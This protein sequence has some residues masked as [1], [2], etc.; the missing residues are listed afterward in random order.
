MKAGK[1]WLCIAVMCMIAFAVMGSSC[2]GSSSS[3]FSEPD[4]DGRDAETQALVDE[5]IA[6]GGLTADETLPDN[7]VNYNTSSATKSLSKT[8]TTQV[9][10]G[11]ALS[12]VTLSPA[13]DTEIWRVYI[14]DDLAASA[15]SPGVSGGEFSGSANGVT[16]TASSSSSAQ[17][18]FSTSAMSTGSNQIEA[19]FVPNA[20]KPTQEIGRTVLGLVSVSSGSSNNNNGN[21]T[22]GNT[23]GNSGGDN[24]SNITSDDNVPDKPASGDN[25]PDRPTSGDN[26]P[27]K[28]TSGDN[29]PDAPT[30]GD[31]VPD[32]PTSGDNVPDAP[33]SGDNVPDTPTSDDQTSDDNTDTTSDDQTGT[34]TGET[35]SSTTASTH[36]LSLT[37]GSATY[38]NITVTKTGDAT[39]SSDGTSGYDWTGSNAAVFAS[40]GGTLT[41]TSA[42]ISSS[43][44]G[45]N[46]VFSYG[47][48][49]NGSNSGNGTTIKISGSTITTTKN[50]SG[51]IMATGGGV[52]NAENLTI[53]TAGGSSA[54]IRSDRGG[55]TIT[56][57]GGT[58]TANGQGSP[59]I[60]STAEITGSDVTLNSG[61]AQVVVIEGGN[62][63]TLT[64]STLNANHTSLNGND[65]Y[66]QAVLIYQSM[67]G[68]ASD[69]SS[70]FTMTDGSLTNANGD[71]FHVTNTTTT[72]ALSGVSITNND[73]SGNFLRA[74]SGKWGSSGSN[75]GKVTLNAS[76]QDMAGNIIV[77]SS[78]TLALSLKDS[79]T[80]NG[81]INSSG[82]AG[83]VSVTIEAGSTWTLTGNSYVTSL[84]NSG[85]ITKGSYTLYVNGTAQ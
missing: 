13:F 64:N 54:A 25:V 34:T 42:D 9:T 1:F 19:S 24:T 32:A 74:S 30:S 7:A 39:G 45:G 47:G 52:I 14:N 51:G 23:G 8:A 15:Y 11:E 82:Q 55:G 72:I 80:F 48:N 10:Q 40:G 66:Y 6:E 46:A 38:S 70:L 65:S 29:V 43:A 44:V 84:S 76:G 16:I 20:S 58:Y 57:S 68:D 12:P 18:T 67:S 22:E 21:S 56:V 50:N 81:A 60:Y 62:S 49:L 33:T 5:I 17:I 83:T 36:A 37:S 59:A 69:G 63:V 41:I 75:G 71:I 4:Q 85:T 2:G 61:I 78:S 73:S 77:D 26:V 31:N 35:Y 28:P 3:N 79:S 27:D 53:T